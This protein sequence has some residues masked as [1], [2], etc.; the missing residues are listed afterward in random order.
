MSPGHVGGCRAHHAAARGC[1]WFAGPS[2]AGRGWGFLEMVDP[3]VTMA[4]NTNMYLVIILLLS[5]RC[6]SLWG[7]ILPHP[8]VQNLRI[9]SGNP[10]KGPHRCP[11]FH[12]VSCLSG[13]P[14]PIATVL[15]YPLVNQQFAMERSTIFHGKI[16]YF[17]GHFP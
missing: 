6:Q 14:E 17:N 13:Q 12:M 10:G 8:Q 16:H 3:Q 15:F 7:V 11:R 1:L 2:E 9:E 4:F 5:D